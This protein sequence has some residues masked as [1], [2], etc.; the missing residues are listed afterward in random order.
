MYTVDQAVNQIEVQHEKVHAGQ[1]KYKLTDWKIS[2]CSGLVALV[3][4]IFK[5]SI[6]DYH[7]QNDHKKKV[8]KLCSCKTLCFLHLKTNEDYYW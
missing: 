4:H 3:I 5:L 2:T 1:Y 7:Y 6:C 8:I